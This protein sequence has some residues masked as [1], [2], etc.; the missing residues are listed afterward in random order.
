MGGTGQHDRGGAD[1][2][3]GRHGDDVERDQRQDGQQR[4]IADPEFGASSVPSVRIVVV[5]PAPLGPR[6]PNTSP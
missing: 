2:K 3:A 4:Q 5:F 6:K 1:R